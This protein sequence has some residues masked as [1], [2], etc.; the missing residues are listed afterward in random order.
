MKLI[1]VFI[2]EAL[3]GVLRKGERGHILQVNNRTKEQ[4]EG[5]EGSDG[6]HV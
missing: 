4:N 5:N 3:L 1:N 6:E 2:I